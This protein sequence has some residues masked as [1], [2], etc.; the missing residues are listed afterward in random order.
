MQQV[1]RRGA[2][3]EAPPRRV[4]TISRQTGC[5]AHEVAIRLA[6]YLQANDTV[7]QCPWTVFDRNLVQKVLE[8]HQLPAV[9]EKYMPEDTRS[10]IAEI[11]DE[12]FGLHP[13]A[14]TLVHKTTETILRLAELGNVIIIGRGANIITSSFKYAFHVRLV[15]SL[16]KRVERVRKRTGMDAAQA[17][18]F[19][20]REDLGRKR[21]LKAYF[22]ADIDDPLLYHMVINTDL[23]PLDLAAQLIGDAVLTLSHT[24]ARLQQPRPA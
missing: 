23:T 17:R 9:F 7:Q 14:W 12:L 16:E 1:A 6:E 3:A 13:S 10:E 15:A 22:D 19:I 20:Q 5:G 8:D 11:M 18:E 21:Y 24:H 2:G 4:V